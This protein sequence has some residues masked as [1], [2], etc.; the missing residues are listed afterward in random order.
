MNKDPRKIGLKNGLHQLS[1]EQLQRVL[2]YPGE[3]ILDTHNYSEGKFCPLAIALELDKTI[4]NPSHDVVFTTLTDMGYKV[5]NTRGIL[6]EYYTSNRKE[7]LLQ[8]A[9]EVIEEKTKEIYSYV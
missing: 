8:A 1:I 6:G 7:D 3:M 2:D 5:Y 4:Q 9:R